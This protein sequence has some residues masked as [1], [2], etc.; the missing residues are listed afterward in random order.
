[1]ID[2]SERLNRFIANL[3]DMTKLESGAIVPNTAPTISARSS[4]ARCGAPARSSRITRSRSNSPPICR[5]WSSMPCCSSRCCSIC[6]TT[7]RNMRRPDTTIS[8]RS[9]RDQ[10]WVL[11]ASH[12][13]RRGHSAGRAGQGVRQVLSR[14]K[15]RSCPPRHRPR[16]RDFPRL[17]RGDARHDLGRQPHRPQRRRADHPSADPGGITRLDTAA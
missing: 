16:P 11:P 12:R 15:R 6:W 7:R 1:M 2:E 4:A 8:I 14:A 3:L 5:C 9:L 17:C 10:G 13:R